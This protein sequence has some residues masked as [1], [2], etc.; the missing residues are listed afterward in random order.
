MSLSIICYFRGFKS[1]PTERTSVGASRLG[2]NVIE[3]N[4]GAVSPFLYHPTEVEDVGRGVHVPLGITFILEVAMVCP[5]SGPL[6]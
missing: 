5:P 2:L 3:F 6:I 4:S 1:L